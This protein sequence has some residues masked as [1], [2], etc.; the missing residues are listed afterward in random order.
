MFDLKEQAT[1]IYL[2]TLDS[3]DPTTIINKKLKLKGEI[4]S[5]NNEYIDLSE[6]EEI[7][8]I[9]FGKASLKMGSS[10]ESLLGERLSRGILVTDRRHNI[11]LK[12]EVIVGGHPLPNE[13]SLEAGRK[14]LETVN[15]IN[16]RTLLLFL[17]SGGGS[18]LVEWPVS[19]RITLDDYRQLN[20]ILVGCGAPIKEINLIRKRISAIKGGRLGYQARNARVIAL[21]FSDVNPDDIRSIASNPLLPESVEPAEQEFI[22]EKYDLRGKIPPSVANYFAEEKGIAFPP[23][24]TD[25]NQPS[26]HLLLGDNQDV[27]R[28]AAIEAIHRGFNTE[29]IE[30]PFEFKYKAVAEGLINRLL[31]LANGERGKPACLLSGGEV[32]CPVS[33]SGA[34]GR[35]QEFVLYSALYLHEKQD[36]ARFAILSC[37]TDGI[38]GN[39][40]AT[41]AVADASTFSQAKS[42]GLNASDFLKRND[43]NAFFRALGGLINTGPAGNNLRD[44]R[45]MLAYL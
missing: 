8:L 9:G 43:S 45:V 23:D 1:Q 11:D 35:N 34:G 28:I 36:L 44:I 5:V 32:I 26:T 16:H 17:I 20:K 3:V 12:S 14:I 31:T 10:V 2:S 25:S 40:T 19:P 13:S 39:S 15:T 7:V 21:Y 27:L 18:S 6:Y 4:L 37:G 22:I 30:T 29:V 33:G 41:G 42:I 24:F 38:D